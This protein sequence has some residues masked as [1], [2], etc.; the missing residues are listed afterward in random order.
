MEISEDEWSQSIADKKILVYRISASFL[1]IN[2]EKAFEKMYDAVRQIKAAS[3]KVAC[4]FSPHEN[5]SQ[6]ENLDPELWKKYSE[7]TELLKRDEDIAY[8]D[9]DIVRSHIDECTAYYGSPGYLAH[10]FGLH[11]K[12]V[13]IMDVNCRSNG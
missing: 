3:N 4:V 6:I 10:V 2:R 1:M 9:H 12:P 8:D 13:M 7:F 5:V 11:G